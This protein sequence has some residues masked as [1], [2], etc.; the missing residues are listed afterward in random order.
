MTYHNSLAIGRSA[1]FASQAAIQ[2][3]G[4]NLAN[5]ATPGFHRRS[6]H[7]LPAGGGVIGNRMYMGNGV[8][9]GQI[10]REIDLALQARWRASISR[11]HS[12]AVDQQFLVAL[13]TLQN[14]LGE[15]DLS[16]ALESFFGS[17]SSLANAP[18]DS[19]LAALALQQGEVL[20]GRMQELMAEYVALD[21]QVGESINATVAACNELLESIA[22]LNGEI[23]AAEGNGQ[24]ASELRD[25]RDL[26]IDQLSVHVDIEVAEQPG[27]MVD[28]RIGSTPI[29]L[30]DQSLGLAVE[31]HAVDGVV[32]LSLHAGAH[33]AQVQLDG[34]TLHG[35]FRQ[36][37]ETIAPAMETLNQ[38]ASSLI[39]HVNRLHSQGQGEN[40]WASLT[41]TV[42]VQD[43]TAA[44]NDTAAAAITPIGNGEFTIHLRDPESGEITDA[45]TIPVDGDVMS[46][47][48][49]VD[50]INA[51]T[52]GAVSASIS[53]NG[54]LRLEA[55]EGLELTFSNDT[56]G[57][58]AGL[59]VNTFF[60]GTDASTIGVNAELIADSGLLAISQGNVI[61]SAGTALAIAQ[62][63]DE[64]S[65]LLGG[66][67]ISAFWRTAVGTLA[68]RTSANA[69]VFESAALVR[70]GLGMQLQTVSGVSIDEESINL[71]AYER[72]FE[73]AARYLAVVDET[74]ETLM[75]LV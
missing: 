6:I 43:V 9:V 55:P 15:D 10:N 53:G 72:Q 54:Q 68:V 42:G 35:L 22:M 32:Q 21:E 71:M 29:L 13:E 59:G 37:S 58:L 16:S 67:G 65:A 28:I 51:L 11:E 19:S 18:T 46:L 62:L 24:E 14:E 33:G 74:L 70:E 44:L 45:F 47:E 52:G 63:G 1:L 3:A 64:E 66:T 69:G 2:I 12:L 23:G 40:G 4:H 30:G 41:G 17:F 50:S 73:A 5:A 31:E 39:H 61:G 26:L 25:Q 8:Q 38:L 20:A 27:G 56:S 49:L 57:A 7:L 48:N 34:G 75:N 60:T 36:H